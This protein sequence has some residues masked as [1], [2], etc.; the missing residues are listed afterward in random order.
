MDS[1]FYSDAKQLWRSVSNHHFCEANDI[2]IQIE[3]NEKLLKF[4]Q[5]GDFYYF[6]FNVFEAEFESISAEILNVLGYKPSD[7]NV[8]FF[9]DKI[10]PQD[11]P[12]FLNFEK[13]IVDFFDTLVPENISKYKVQYDFRIKNVHGNYIRILHQLIILQHSANILQRSFGLHTDITHIKPEGIPLLSII[14]LEGEPSYFNIQPSTF[15]QKSLPILSKREMQILRCIIE[16]KKSHEI[17]A[18]LFISIHTVNSHRKKILDKTNSKTAS[19]LIIKTI[20]EG[21]L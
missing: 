2:E 10:H 8:G 20:N 21:W 9:V 6:I 4:F 5:A 3:I 1:K 12:Y 11:Q 16:G 13:T 14:G 19:E 15:F 7:I 18:T 17:A